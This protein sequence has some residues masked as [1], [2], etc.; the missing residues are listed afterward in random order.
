M[1]KI[2]SLYAIEGKSTYEI[3][4]TLN[5]LGIPTPAESYHRAKEY[6]KQRKKA[7]WLQTSVTGILRNPACIGALA[8]GKTKQALCENIPLRLIP[9]DNWEIDFWSNGTTH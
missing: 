1:R 5:H 7:I 4:R 6:T 3:T 9:K 8:Y 2:F